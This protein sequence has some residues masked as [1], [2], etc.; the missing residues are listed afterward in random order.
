M[1]LSRDLP[2]QTAVSEPFKACVHLALF[3]LSVAAGLYNL[4]ESMQ[5]PKERHLKIN[6]IAY[7]GVTC[8][9]VLQIA[10]HRKEM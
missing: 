10:K 4:S 8:Y 3:G 7:L 6:A 2:K 5:R 1:L 9:E